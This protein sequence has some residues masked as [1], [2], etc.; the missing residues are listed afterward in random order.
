MNNSLPLN[1]LG[2]ISSE[3][4]SHPYLFLTSFSKDLSLSYPNSPP[5]GRGTFM[6]S[7]WVATRTTWSGFFNLPPK[8]RG[9]K[10]TL[11]EVNIPYTPL[12]LNHILGSIPGCEDVKTACR[13]MGSSSL[14]WLTD[15][16]KSQAWTTMEWALILGIRGRLFKMDQNWL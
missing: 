11:S 2:C 1:Y 3:A 6:M 7:A 10:Q 12:L 14:C 4:S 8:A 5:A 15:L 13:L 16:C 9:R